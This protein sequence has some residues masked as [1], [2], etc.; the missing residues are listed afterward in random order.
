MPRFIVEVSGDQPVMLTYESEEDCASEEQAKAEALKFAREHEG[1]EMEWEGYG[2]DV[3][4]IQ[5]HAVEVE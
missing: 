3:Y 4:N 5:I 2:L 1:D